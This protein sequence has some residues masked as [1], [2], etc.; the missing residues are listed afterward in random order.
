MGFSLCEEYARFCF[1]SILKL[2]EK[3]IKVSSTVLYFSVIKCRIYPI[4][5]ALFL[6]LFAS[7]Y[8]QNYSGIMCAC[9]FLCHSICILL[10][11]CIWNDFDYTGPGLCIRLK[12]SPIMLLSASIAQKFTCYNYM[13][14]IIFLYCFKYAYKFYN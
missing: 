5:P 11:Q 7:Y 9:L 14:N 6:I 8:S 4:I 12:F 13:L 3:L 2:Y 1:G 10:V